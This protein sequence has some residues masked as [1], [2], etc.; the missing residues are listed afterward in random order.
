MED[1]L[2][3]E[4]D[5]LLL[6]EKEFHDAARRNDTARMAE[7]IERGVDVKAKNNLDRTALHWAAGAGHV[8]A[9]RLLLAHDAAV[10]DE[11][12]FGMNALLL[13][14]WFGHLR[15]VQILVN[16]GAKTNCVNKNGRGLLHCAA[17]RGHI[18]VI[19][20]L[21][22]DL[23]DVRLDKKDKMERTAF[24][25]AAENGQLEVVKFLIL[26]GC[27]CSIKDKDKNTAMHLA[28]K[29][30]HAEVLQKLIEAGMS[31]DEKNRELKA[32]CKNAPPLYVQNNN[33]ARTTLSREQGQGIFSLPYIVGLYLPSF[34]TMGILAGADGFPCPES[35]DYPRLA[36]C[37]KRS[38]HWT[39]IVE[40][41]RETKRKWRR[42]GRIRRSR[43]IRLSAG[44]RA[45][46]A[47]DNCPPEHS[48]GAHDPLPCQEGL[49]A[50]HLAAEGGHH[51]CLR[52]LLEAG[53]DVRAQT[54]VSRS[55]RK[56]ISTSAE[57]RGGQEEVEQPRGTDLA[58]CFKASCNVSLAQKKMT[59]LHYAA[60]NG[61]EDAARMLI[62]AG[63]QTDAL[64]FQ[65]ASAMH[66][67]VLQN[68]PALV[69]LL[70][71]AECDLDILDNRQQSPLHIAAEHGRQEIAEMI[72]IAGVNLKLTDKAS[73]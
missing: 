49:T 29:N 41:V 39:C 60:L 67:A 15:I 31:L 27:K 65:N 19:E 22:E 16:A 38:K 58:G 20:F 63:V 44:G 42:E 61:F 28:A 43:S 72:L 70:I 40:D 9:V 56:V 34:L 52:L 3:S 14:A 21:I 11:D 51:G 23:E 4:D 18:N 30:G 55:R 12:N 54:Q 57:K 71:D 69:R 5:T 35:D 24:H 50:L 2:A 10:N 6:S 26:A 64:N 13:S 17:Q 47:C 73:F 68:H 36:K 53:C 62:A 46:P 59:C 66:I 7:L 32:A 45:S 33:P 25:L 48:R 8:Q 1:D 37:L